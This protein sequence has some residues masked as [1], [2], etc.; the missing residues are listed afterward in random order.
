MAKIPK[1]DK[2]V[3]LK[4]WDTGGEERFRSM[5]QLYYRDAIGA[6][7]CY[8]MSNEKSFA[9]TTYWINEMI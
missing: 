7:I 4:V 2:K 5:V 9:E 1:P 3:T 8:D 6:I